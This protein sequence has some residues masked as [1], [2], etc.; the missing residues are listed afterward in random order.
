MK[1]NSTWSPFQSPE[2]QEICKHLTP[3]ER[4]RLIDDARARGT[5]IGWWLAVPFGL[6]AGSLFVSWRVGVVLLV[7]YALYFWLSGL[8]RLRAMRRRTTE[9]LCDTELARRWGYTPDRLRLTV[10]PWSR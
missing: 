6:A 4:Q 10:F 1:T 2:V 8:P 7:L 5:E 9:L 3:A